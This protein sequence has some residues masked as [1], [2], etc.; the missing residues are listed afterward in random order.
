MLFKLNPNPTFVGTATI[1]VPG[2]EAQ[3]LR[4]I[5]KHKTRKSDRSHVVL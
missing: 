5:F 3:K 1:A 4:L 2:G